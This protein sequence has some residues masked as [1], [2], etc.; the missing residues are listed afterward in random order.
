[1]KKNYCYVMPSLLVKLSIFVLFSST[2]IYCTPQS[3][4][5]YAI[6]IY[7]YN[8][9]SQE[10]RIDKFLQNAY[11]PSLHRAGIEKVGVFKPVETDTVSGKRIYVLLPLTSL[12]QLVTLPQKLEAD[13]QFASD[14]QEYLK[15]AYDNPAFTRMETIVL[16]AFSGKPTFDVPELKTPNSERIYEL[17]SYESPTKMLHKNKV[18]MF[19]KGSEIGLF[20]RLGFNAV[21]YGKVLAGSH[22]P[23]LMYMTTFPNMESR[24]KHW[25]TFVNDPEWK[26]MSAMEEYQHNVSHSDI[27]LLHPTAYSDI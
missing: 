11:L 15:A 27:F 20:E 26:K 3:R 18:E 7:H 9:K 5:F 19:N 12:D 24:N 13:K 2:L 8:D 21:F 1:M 6:K 10:E 23:N 22:M 25:D 14:G 17:R 16:Q 4:D